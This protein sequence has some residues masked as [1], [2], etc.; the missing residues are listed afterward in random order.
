MVVPLLAMLGASEARAGEADKELSTIARLGPACT[1]LVDAPLGSNVEACKTELH[2][3]AK[4]LRKFVEE[5]KA[6]RIE[7]LAGNISNA[8]LCSRAVTLIDGKKKEIDE[9]IDYLSSLISPDGNDIVSST[10]AKKT[11]TRLRGAEGRAVS[12]AEYEQNVRQAL[13]DAREKLVSC[14][15]ALRTALSLGGLAAGR[16]EIRGKLPDLLDQLVKD[17]AQTEDVERLRGATVT[18]VHILDILRTA[19]KTR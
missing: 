12:G 3:T 9:I 18:L 11:M 8:E 5:G 14:G 16:A 13:A 17:I 10:L 15:F 2:D 4:S 1:Q 19:A 7:L 6:G